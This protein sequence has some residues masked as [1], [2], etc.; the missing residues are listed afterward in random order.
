MTQAVLVPALST[1]ER[2]TPAERKITEELVSNS[3]L[4]VRCMDETVPMTE[5]HDREVRHHVHHHARTRRSGV[6]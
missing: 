1:P 2:I 3:G 4:P 5:G 6:A